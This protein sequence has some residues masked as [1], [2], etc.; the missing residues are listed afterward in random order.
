MY[1]ATSSCTKLSTK[2]V[3][4]FHNE[5]AGRLPVATQKG[6]P[7]SS[8]DRARPPAGG[9]EGIGLDPIVHRVARTNALLGVACVEDALRTQLD[10]KKHVRQLNSFDF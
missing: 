3:S 1:E 5:G 10:V 8:V 7:V 6:S 2:C 4:P 9:D